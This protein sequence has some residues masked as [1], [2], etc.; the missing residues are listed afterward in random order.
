MTAINGNVSDGPPRFGQF[1]WDWVEVGDAVT[2]WRGTAEE[3]RLDMPL[4]LEGGYPDEI[5]DWLEALAASIRKATSCP[6]C[7]LV[8]HAVLERQDHG[9]HQMVVRWRPAT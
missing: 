7:H 6:E 8:L 2:V 9:F 3:P 1:V 5:A 4:L